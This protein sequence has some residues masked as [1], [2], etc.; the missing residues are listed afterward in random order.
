MKM[1]VGTTPGNLFSMTLRKV[2]PAAIKLCM[3]GMSSK[4]C[5]HV[6]EELTLM[7]N[8]KKEISFTNLAQLAMH[9]MLL[10]SMRLVL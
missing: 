1:H 5:P 8:K 4:N 3:I 2:G 9:K 6:Q 7:L 10:K